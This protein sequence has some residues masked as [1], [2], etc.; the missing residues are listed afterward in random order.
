MDLPPNVVEMI[1]HHVRFH[2][3]P[4]EPYEAMTDYG[5]QEVEWKCYGCKAVG[6]S[7]WPAWKLEMTHEPGCAWVAWCD[8]LG[9][10]SSDPS[11]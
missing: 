1:R 11:V 2:G 3:D 5:K 8:A 10:A 4:F 7:K 9:Q 6:L